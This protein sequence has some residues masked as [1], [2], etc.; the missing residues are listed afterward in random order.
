MKHNRQT[1]GQAV[2]KLQA[3]PPI[4]S[5]HGRYICV[6]RM[7]TACCWSLLWGNARLPSTS[8]SQSS[9]NFSTIFLV[10]ESRQ[11]CSAVG[12]VAYGH[13]AITAL[14]HHHRRRRHYRIGSPWKHQVPLHPPQHECPTGPRVHSTGTE[15]WLWGPH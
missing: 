7:L 14:H 2:I 10:A 1:Y 15:L 3:G 4:V 9:S 11:Y 13:S 5:V 8:H 12:T 6:M